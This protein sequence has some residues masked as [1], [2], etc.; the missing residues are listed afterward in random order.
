MEIENLLKDFLDNFN[1]ENIYNEFSLQ[2]ELGIFLREKLKKDDYKVQF[3]RNVGSFFGKDNVSDM[4]K[5][6][7]D[8]V[9][10]KGDIVNTK[11][12]YAIELKF[13]VNGQYPEQ[14]Y[15]FIKDIKFVEQLHDKGFK[16][17]YTLTIVNQKPFYYGKKSDGIYKYFRKNE[18]IHGTISKPTGKDKTT[19]SISLNRE[20]NIV[21]NDFKKLNKDSLKNYRY[22]II[23]IQ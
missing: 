6:E 3:E 12:K 23:K 15:S 19:K 9:I 20:Y 10:Y 16:N 22:Y 2:H 13:P 21:W 5:K 14:M 18:T 1:E 7:I 11:E 8:I 4:V 17:T